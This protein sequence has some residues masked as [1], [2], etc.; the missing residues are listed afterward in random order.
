MDTHE[1]HNGHG[2]A[3]VVGSVA[4]ILAGIAIHWGWNTFT[5]EVLSQPPLEFKHSIALELL[6]VSIAS[7]FPLTWRAFGA[8]SR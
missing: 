8:N 7:I 3:I 6:V 1:N 4:F 2:K 5:V